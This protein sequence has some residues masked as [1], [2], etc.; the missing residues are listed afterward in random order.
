M[1][2]DT[3]IFASTLNPVGDYTATLSPKLDGLFLFGDRAFLT[4]DARFDYTA[5]AQH[6]DQNFTNKR[7]KAR[8]KLPVRRQ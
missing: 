7:G 1:G 3:N 2:Y 8:M 5:Y 4:F 6:T